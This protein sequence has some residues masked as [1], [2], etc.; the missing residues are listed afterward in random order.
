M[1]RRFLFSFVVVLTLSLPVHA[2]ELFGNLLNCPYL[3]LVD[4][5]SSGQT[6]LALIQEQIK[7]TLDIYALHGYSCL[8]YTSDA[9]DE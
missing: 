2:H 5:T 3:D 1:L 9:A 7:P 6:L 8:L 4:D